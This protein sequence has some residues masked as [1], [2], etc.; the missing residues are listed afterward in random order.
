MDVDTCAEATAYNNWL[1]LAQRTSDASCKIYLWIFNSVDAWIRNMIAI[2]T[3]DGRAAFAVISEMFNKP[4]RM[5]Q[6]RL[7][8]HF[9]SGSF[10]GK[11]IDALISQI[12]DSQAKFNSMGKS[13]SL[14]AILSKVDALKRAVSTVKASPGISSNATGRIASSI[15]RA[16]SVLPLTTHRRVFN[17]PTIIPAHFDGISMSM[18][19]LENLVKSI[20][21]K[22]IRVISDNDKASV[23]LRALMVSDV[24]RALAGY[25]EVAAPDITYD[26]LVRLARTKNCDN[27][28]QDDGVVTRRQ[29]AYAVDSPAPP[30]INT[31]LKVCKHQGKCRHGKSEYH[32]NARCT[33]HCTPTG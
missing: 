30:R 8:A 33:L 21:V 22:S 29:T 7:I 20:R 23:L 15:L 24:Y 31:P 12:N 11:D 13:P 4:S 16:V 25:V 32:V 19:A 17:A 9:Y 18:L 28:I 14:E 5:L 3:G 10:A 2:N 1:I 6:R 27:H 26:D